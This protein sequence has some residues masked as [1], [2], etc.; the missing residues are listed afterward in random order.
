[1]IERA[2]SEPR[3][4]LVLGI[5]GDGLDEA[6]DAVER[7]AEQAWEQEAIDLLLQDKPVPLATAA[8]LVG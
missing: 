1:M 8:A 4:L 7:G 2:G 3:A 6:L 5:G